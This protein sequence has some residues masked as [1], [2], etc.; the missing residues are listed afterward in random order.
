MG[1]III[2]GPPAV[3]KM[4]IGQ[5]IAEKTGYKLFHNH[6]SIDM[7]SPIFP[8]GTDGF[9]NSVNSIRTIIFE[10]AALAKDFKGLIF[11]VCWAFNIEED[12][13]EIKAFA[14]IFKK[15]NKEVFFLELFS[16]LEI[17]MARN[18]TE[19]RLKHKAPKRDLEWSDKNL[20]EMEAEYVMNSDGHILEDEN[21]IRVDNS[22]LSPAEV[23]DIFQDKFNLLL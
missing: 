21:Y 16:D 3:G 5:V 19:N 18:H 15:Q 8:F 12:N 1:F 14:E 20:L 22:D 6:I 10:Q 23:A 4:T 7:V 2:F 13:D 17:R 9:Q 11:T